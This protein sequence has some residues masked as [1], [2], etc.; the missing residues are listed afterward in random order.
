MFNQ[1]QYQIPTNTTNTVLIIEEA[2]ISEFGTTAVV[3]FSHM[4]PNRSNY[5]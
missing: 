3:Q 2:H 5:F 1:Q 4:R